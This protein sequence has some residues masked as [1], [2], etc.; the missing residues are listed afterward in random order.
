M[1]VAFANESADRKRINV[2]IDLSQNSTTITTKSSVATV[3][4]SSATSY[5]TAEVGLDYFFHSNYALT[6]QLLFPL[7]TSVDAQIA[8]HDIGFKYFF[9]KPG[10]Q[11]EVKL[12]K[13]ELESTPGWTSFIYGGYSSRE[14][15][16]NNY[17]VLFQGLE[18]GGG[19]DFHFKQHY[20][21]RGTLTYQLLNNSSIRSLDGY[22]AA[23]G[24]GYSF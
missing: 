12:K 14:F 22:T 9:K 24:M 10:H 21:L 20:F 7:M 19:I 13:S 2:F 23:L 15:Q 8:G 17:S 6:L 11:S 18:L 3:A 16:F 5:L 4:A 1:N